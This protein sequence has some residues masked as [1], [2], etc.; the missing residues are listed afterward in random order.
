MS[1]VCELP[2]AVRAANCACTIARANSEAGPQG[3]RQGWRESGPAG[4]ERQSVRS[5]FQCIF[6]LALALLQSA[7]CA[8]APRI[9]VVTM[10][11][12]DEYWARFGHDAILVDDRA[13]DPSSE[14]TLYNFGYFDLDEPGFMLHFVQ[15]RANYQLVALPAH[16]DLAQYAHAGRG[17]VLQWLDFTPAQ[18]SRL[19][20]DLEW[21][22]RPE[23]A[24]Y[25]YDYFTQDCT[26][27][28]RDAL[29]R[30]LDGRLRAQLSAPSQGL[31]YRYEAVRLGAPEPWLG[32]G[33][34]FALGPYA[35]RP[36]SRW[37]EAFIPE[38][39]QASLR[40]IRTAAG[41][42]L[43]TQ[44]IELLPQRLP[45]APNDFPRWR[46]WFVLTGLGLAVLTLVGA[47]F[48]PRTTAAF[49]GLFWLK[50][51]LLGIGL[52]AIWAFT[53][54]V[55]IWGNENVLLTS[56]LCLALLPGAWAMLHGRNPP[57]WHA[58]VL[59][60]VAVSAGTAL[61][62]KF[63]PFRIQSNGDWIALFLPIHLALAYAGRRTG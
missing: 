13:D 44:E 40:T 43:V 62:L 11:P 59:F 10:G 21:N 49:A 23:N 61:F 48:A 12:G 15:G 30:A 14:P 55:A 18:A 27:R 37:D 36:L 22:A 6:F 3:E 56:P 32:L 28:V 57:R 39:L 42:P 63:L 33:M 58:K 51:G 25:R 19:Q 9:G 50:C 17:A 47:R 20:R 53:A 8:A 7:V 31:T 1:C 54:H 52:L 26:T 35:D 41:T 5:C 38:R 2:V 45:P 24:R 16:E 46:I 34:H 4:R 60:L 29:D